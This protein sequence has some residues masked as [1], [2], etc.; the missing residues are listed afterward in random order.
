MARTLQANLNYIRFNEI[1]LAKR[2]ISRPRKMM[3]FKRQKSPKWDKK[4]RRSSKEHLMKSDGNGLRMS[5]QRVMNY[6]KS[7]SSPRL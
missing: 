2:G 6:L 5:K 1:L 7:Q 4:L 3:L